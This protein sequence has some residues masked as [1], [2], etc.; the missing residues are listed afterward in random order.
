ML[1][2]GIAVGEFTVV[3][4]Q[5]TRLFLLHPLIQALTYVSL[6]TNIA[7]RRASPR[8]HFP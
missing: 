1:S 2:R 5:R 7:P 4:M 6:P 8:I 3:R